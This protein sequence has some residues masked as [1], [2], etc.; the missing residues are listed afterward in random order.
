[1]ANGAFESP[2]TGLSNGPLRIA[3]GQSIAAQTAMGSIY[4][5]NHDCHCVYTKSEYDDYT[6]VLNT[7]VKYM[8]VMDVA[9]CI[10]M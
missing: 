2:R 10:I 8:R 5:L 6:R 3:N 4:I 9:K 1:M 7:C